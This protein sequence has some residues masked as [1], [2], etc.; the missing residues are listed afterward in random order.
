[1]TEEEN[2]KQEVRTSSSG[3][4]ILVVGLVC[5]AVIV[6]FFATMASKT[7]MVV[8]IPTIGKQ[9]RDVS[10]PYE[11]QEEY[12]KTEYYTETVPYTDKECESKVL[13]YSM[14]N[15]AGAEKCNQK[16][17]ECQKYFLGVCTE[18]K[19]YCLDT[20]VF[21]SVDVN[22]MDDERGTLTIQFNALSDNT[23]AGKTVVS[24]TLYPHSTETIRGQIQI[25]TKEPIYTTHSC[26]YSVPNEPTKQVC[27][28]VTKY[29]DVQKERQV[30][31]YRPVTKYR[32][33]NQCD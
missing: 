27:R 32:T 8:N 26:T 25:T 29:K 20:T 31:A 7:G 6:I 18:K 5:V 4:K 24:Q 9:C 23:Y 28:D 14:D 30:T 10:V 15:L 16:L 22:N 3:N 17:D 11:L 12:V 33:E 21:C 2:I 1:V 13:I 19:T